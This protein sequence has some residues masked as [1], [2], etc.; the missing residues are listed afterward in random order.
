M[1]KKAFVDAVTVCFERLNGAFIKKK[2]SPLLVLGRSHRFPNLNVLYNPFRERTPLSPGLKLLTSAEAQ[3]GAVTI[4]IELNPG[5]RAP[6]F[7]PTSGLTNNQIQTAGEFEPWP[8]K[9]LTL[10]MLREMGC[11]V[12]A[13]DAEGTI[14]KLREIGAPNVSE[15]EVIRVI[16]RKA[17]ES[18]RGRR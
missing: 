10:K 7:N 17:A 13:D 2:G 4:C 11:A 15:D 9:K 5:P 16:I 12:L 6:V 8:D 18:R 1:L 3:E 14:N